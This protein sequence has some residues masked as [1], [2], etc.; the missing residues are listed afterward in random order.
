MQ[1][2]ICKLILLASFASD[3]LLHLFSIG[4]VA[5]EAMT[6][7]LFESLKSSAGSLKSTHLRD[8]LKDEAR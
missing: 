8:L 3:L 6:E 1:F 5:S 4:L 7:K 2:Q